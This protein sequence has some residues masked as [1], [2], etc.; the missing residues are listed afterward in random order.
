MTSHSYSAWQKY[1]V[2]INVLSP[3]PGV[4]V[5]DS[6]VDKEPNPSTWVKV[7]NSGQIA[8]Q[9]AL[10]NVQENVHQYSEQIL[11]GIF[12]LIEYCSPP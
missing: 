4:T 9:V 11:K 8:V 5:T 3:Q 6:P 2:R 12:F 10:P 1:T 7:Y